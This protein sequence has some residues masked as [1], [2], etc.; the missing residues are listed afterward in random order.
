[1]S[2]FWAAI[3]IVI[4]LWLVFEFGIKNLLDQND[5]PDWLYNC[6]FWWIIPV[7]IGIAIIIAGVKGLT[8][9]R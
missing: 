6:E 8:S 1:M 5:M 7:I 4:G 2:W 9:R 3:I